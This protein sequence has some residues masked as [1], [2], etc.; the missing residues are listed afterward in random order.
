M[1]RRR[2]AD[3]GEMVR[4]ID[5][6]LLN[7]VWENGDSM[8]RLGP[9]GGYE[10]TLG[11]LTCAVVLE[12]LALRRA[13]EPAGVVPLSDED[14]VAWRVPVVQAAED[15]MRKWLADQTPEVRKAY[16]VDG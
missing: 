8:I 9:P 7:T 4:L 6:A 3:P 2:R 14:F 1:R 16:G 12:N 11:I 5:E 13:Y 15:G 10:R